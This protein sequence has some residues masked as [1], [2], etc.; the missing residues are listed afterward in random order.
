MVTIQIT[1]E[2]VPGFLRATRGA[3][4]LT[5]RGIGAAIGVSHGTVSKWERGEGE[6]SVSQFILW[7][8]AT[9]QSP[10][11]MIEALSAVVRPKGLEPL[12][13]WSVADS[14]ALDLEYALLCAVED[15]TL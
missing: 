15:V 1:A 10:D 13:F 2:S 14:Q 7:C 6:P 8:R 5:T 12:T 9:Q 4:G 3:A 11:Q